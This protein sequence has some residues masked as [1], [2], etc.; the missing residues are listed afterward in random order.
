MRF[1]KPETA[2]RDFRLNRINEP[3]YRHLWWL[4]FWPAYLLRYFII[5]NW[6]PAESYHVM[7]CALDDRIPFHEGFLIF[8]VFWYFFIV[9][10]HLYTLLYDADTF[11]RY[12][13]FLCISITIS[14]AVFLLY[15]SCQQLR[16][17]RLPRQNLLSRAVA[18]IYAVDTN[19][20]VFPSE[21]VIGALAALAA[22][23][24]TE[25]LRKP[26][27]LAGLTLLTVLICA[28][29]L[30]LKQHSVLDILGALSVCTIA[31]LLC[32]EKRGYH[33]QLSC[34]Y[35]YRLHNRKTG[36]SQ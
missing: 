25:R 6:N 23:A 7:H 1:P 22:A 32:Y 26:G 4:L 2:L 34:R 18:L 35:R 21:H 13:K 24:H 15:P 31:Y 5:E 9:G 12:S 10:I 17:E 20:N 19:T 27:C 8:Y 14:T 33:E 36:Y 29:T 28:S 16:P 30:F 3:Q 11:R